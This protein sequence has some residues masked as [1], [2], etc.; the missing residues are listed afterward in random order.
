M[1]NQKMTKRNSIGQR[2]P[3]NSIYENKSPSPSSQSQKSPLSRQGTVRASHRRKNSASHSLNLSTGRRSP[4]VPLDRSPSGR[5]SPN[6]LSDNIIV[7]QEK[8]SPTRSPTGHRSPLGFTGL[9]I[10]QPDRRSSPSKEMAIHSWNER[11]KSPTSSI[12]F[13]DRKSPVLTG[14]N[15]GAFFLEPRRSPINQLPIPP[16]TI[17]NASDTCGYS[18]KSIDSLRMPSPKEQQSPINRD[19]ED[20]KVTEPPPQEKKEKTSVMRELLAFVRKPSKKVSTRTSRFAAAFSK[21]NNDSNAPLVRQSTFSNMPNS[22]S[23]AGRTAV[24]KQMSY[25]P[26]ISSKLKS[27]GSKMSLRLRRATEIKKDN[28][29]SSGDEISDMESSERVMDEI[30]DMESNVLEIE[31]IYFEKVSGVMCED[32]F[33]GFITTVKVFS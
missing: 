14:P 11:Q 18:P 6:Y 2:S 7:H 19:R 9:S 30:S 15:T 23:R 13:L 28:K 1:D 5:H 20:N 27:V 25:E 16:I 4:M 3:S 31:S 29:K 10:C 24:T 12:H 17:S 22:S 8:K 32:N 26:K 21:S 33:N